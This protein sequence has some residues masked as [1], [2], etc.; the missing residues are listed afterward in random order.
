MR[1][2]FTKTGALG[3]LTCL[4][5]ASP[6]LAADPPP[7]APAPAP[8]DPAASPAPAAQAPA[9]DPG[10]APAAAP[11]GEQPANPDELTEEGGAAE[12][13][14]ANEAIF[15]KDFAKAARLAH[16]AMKKTKPSAE[17]YES[18]QFA[19]AQSLEKL[20]LGQGAAEYYFAVAE[21]RQNPALLSRAL[22]GLARLSRR[23][24]LDEDKL[25]RGVLVEAEL[26]NIPARVADFLHYYRG[27]AN[28]RQ[29]Y[30]KWSKKD[31]ALVR[32][33]SYYGRRVALAE[34]VTLVK[35]DK[36][37]EALDVIDNFLEGEEKRKEKLRAERGI[38]AKA[39]E[40]SDSKTS[41]DSKKRAR[42]TRVKADP[43]VDASLIRARL[44]Y[45][46]GEFEDAIAQYVQ[47]GR[48]PEAPAGE[49]LLER[50]WAHF[51]DLSYHDAMG[52]LY[53]LGAPSN[54]ELFLP[55]QYVL[56]GLIYQR[57][58]H[59][60]AAKASVADFRARYGESIATLRNGAKPLEVPVIAKAAA[61]LPDVAPVVRVAR[62]L[63][64]EQKRLVT[65]ADALQEGG[66]GEHLTHVY[67]VLSERSAYS[68]Q[69]TMEDAGNKIADRLLEADEQANLLEYEV[70]VSI[71]R[72]IRDA[73]GKIRVRAAAEEVPGGGPRL[74]YHFDGEFWSDEL[75]DMRFL[76]QDRCVE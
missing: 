72:P 6:A 63:D 50:A 58:C 3:A 74:Y 19:L 62:A 34:A 56:R 48:T 75:P 61:E 53:S 68:L 16:V 13:S 52:L 46:K 18:A 57:F 17:K 22:A 76:I 39:Q 20:G 10:A 9:G 38:L 64:T 31:F 27:L 37:D 29:G 44:L 45:E 41:A 21:Q 28:L 43:V 14:L 65:M 2:I 36:V 49:L 11:G 66:I 69:R 71:F 7:A 12:L 5:L 4:L 25:L 1:S 35:E 73:T 30:R 40:A 47:V 8:A 32:P 54:R 59:F 24:E 23:G 60:R 26:S 42:T 51:R 70:G 55:D 67:Q 33:N 15:L